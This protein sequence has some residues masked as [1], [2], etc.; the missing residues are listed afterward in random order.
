MRSIQTDPLRLSNPVHRKR[1]KL[2][3]LFPPSLVL[4]SNDKAMGLLMFP[5]TPTH[6]FLN[7]NKCGVSLIQLPGASHTGAH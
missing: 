4:Y 7:L 3:A 2:K 6:I 1:V 5:N